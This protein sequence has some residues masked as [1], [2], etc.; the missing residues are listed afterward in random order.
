MDRVKAVTM[1][2]PW[3]MQ[4][5]I[6]ER[7]MEKLHENYISPKRL[8]K[9]N[10]FEVW[11]IKNI[12]GEVKE[13]CD[14]KYDVYYVFRDVFISILMVFFLIWFSLLI[15]KK[16]SNCFKNTFKKPQRANEVQAIP[17]AAVL[18]SYPVATVQIP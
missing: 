5:C 6:E 18:I 11:L 1:R 7:S 13:F 4:T 15:F 12:I 16:W 8:K 3:L 14:S 2:F 10:A 17:L 9:G